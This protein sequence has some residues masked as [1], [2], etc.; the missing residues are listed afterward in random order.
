VL[1]PPPDYEVD[2][3]A[4]A[5][6]DVDDSSGRVVLGL[7]YV[8]PRGYDATRQV[9]L[10]FDADGS[11]RNGMIKDEVPG[12]GC[13]VRLADLRQG[14]LAVKVV[15]TNRKGW[16]DSSKQAV[17]GGDIDGPM[18]KLVHPWDRDPNGGV[19]MSVS[20]SSEQ[21]TVSTRTLGF[22]S[23]A[24]ETMQWHQVFQPE[25]VPGVDS[26]G[27]SVPQNPGV[28]DADQEPDDGFSLADSQ[29]WNRPMQYVEMSELVVWDRAVFLPVTAEGPS[30]FS[31]WDPEYG[32]RTLLQDVE[33]EEYSGNLG[34][35]GRDM[36]WTLERTEWP[37]NQRTPDREYYLMTAPFTTDPVV[38][39]SQ[40]RMLG[41]EWEAPAWE[42]SSYRVG[43]GYAAHAT[44]EGALILTRLAD[45]ANWTVRWHYYSDRDTWN[46]GK[47]LGVTC[48]E[49]FAVLYSRDGYPGT[50]YGS[51]A[52]I[53]IDSL[54]EPS[55]PLK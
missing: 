29:R 8:T 41:R 30:G 24:W 2:T 49:V 18:A 5:F 32:L 7:G 33:W 22:A 4:G 12:R 43:C 1:V 10:V 42:T 19:G 52:R 26:F 3:E 14:K 13:P 53:R 47:V 35:D 28:K 27:A 25:A 15:G 38:F 6:A 31:S 11:T 44:H 51:V 55:P 20:V 39:A 34:T 16:S 9:I 23:A 17:L 46:F 45:G 48:E 54:G 40:T 21:L 36:A 50:R 37:V